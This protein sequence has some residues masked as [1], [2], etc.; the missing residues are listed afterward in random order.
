[1]RKLSTM[2]LLFTIL[3][4]TAC[5]ATAGFAEM[6]TKPVVKIVFI[7]KQSCCNCTQSAIDKSWAALEAVQKTLPAPLPVERIHMDTQASQAAKY[8]NMKAMIAVPGLYLLDSEGALVDL[9]QGE[10]SKKQL[11]EKLK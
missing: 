8:Q 11:N 10:V 6:S 4:T 5:F 3:V 9:L 2:I 7:D 1:M